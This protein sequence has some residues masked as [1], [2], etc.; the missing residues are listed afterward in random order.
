[1][2]GMQCMQSAIFFLPRTTKRRERP[3]VFD[4]RFR[5]Q[6]QPRPYEIYF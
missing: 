4:F 3:Y 5:L 6:A 1:M 2:L